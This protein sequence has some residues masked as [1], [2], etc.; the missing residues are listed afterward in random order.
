MTELD[1]FD[2]KMFQTS[3]Q[4]YIDAQVQK[5]L[6]RYKD[7]LETHGQQIVQYVV[8]EEQKLSKLAKQFDKYLTVGGELKDR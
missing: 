6:A 3:L 7:D 1:D 4:S 5:A 8:E 2:L